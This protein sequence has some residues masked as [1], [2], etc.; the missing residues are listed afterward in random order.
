[1]NFRTN[2]T[3]NQ[4]VRYPD[5]TYIW[6]FAEEANKPVSIPHGL[7]VTPRAWDIVDSDK[8]VD[9]YR[10]IMDAQKLV[11]VFNT[12]NTHIVLRIN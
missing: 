9:A 4:P 10:Q 12:A 3:L 8:A 5:G 11:L 1:M 7:G 2:L 6:I